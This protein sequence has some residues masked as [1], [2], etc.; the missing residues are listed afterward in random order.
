MPW[1]SSSHIGYTHGGYMRHSS[2]NCEYGYLANAQESRRFTGT[3]RLRLLQCVITGSDSAKSCQIIYV[4]KQS[5]PT[6][7]ITRTLPDTRHD[8]LKY[9]LRFWYMVEGWGC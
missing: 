7:G 9:V 6:H 2:S 3:D 4:T 8:A 1:A 5:L